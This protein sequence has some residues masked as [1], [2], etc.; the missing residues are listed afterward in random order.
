MFQSPAS[1][2]RGTT[3]IKT[4]KEQSKTRKDQIV[5]S[6]V[7]WQDGRHGTYEKQ[8]VVSPASAV[9]NGSSVP[10]KMALTLEITV[11]LGAHKVH[12]VTSCL[13]R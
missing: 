1:G 4:E 9:G 11:G 12:A 13:M 5:K 7:V 3:K 8:S 10:R 6:R 2:E